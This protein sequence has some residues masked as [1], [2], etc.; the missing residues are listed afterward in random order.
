M[1]L[2][3]ILSWVVVGGIAYT[4]YNYLSTG[5]ITAIPPSPKI[6]LSLANKDKPNLEGQRKHLA[7]GTPC[8][9]I[10]GGK[11]KQGIYS[12]EIQQF[13]GPSSYDTP[14]EKTYSILI[15]KRNGS[16]QITR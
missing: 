2:G 14:P 8:I 16:W 6:V 12:C 9:R 7:T 3:R 10:A 4:S 13:A 1:D 5:D 11:I 15:T